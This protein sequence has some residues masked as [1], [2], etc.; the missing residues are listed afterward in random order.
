MSGAAYPCKVCE[1][2]PSNRVHK[3]R[4]R[5]GYHEYQPPD[6]E[7]RILTL[8]ERVAALESWRDQLEMDI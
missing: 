8:E 4:G 7:P 1:C 3:V 6:E 2:G 5:Y